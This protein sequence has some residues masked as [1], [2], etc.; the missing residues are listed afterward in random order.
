MFIQNVAGFDRCR[1]PHHLDPLQTRRRQLPVSSGTSK[2]AGRRHGSVSERRDRG[3]SAFVVR[4][5]H[6]EVRRCH[7]IFHGPVR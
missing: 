1:G 6:P 4:Q 3:E 5:A 2:A 7:R